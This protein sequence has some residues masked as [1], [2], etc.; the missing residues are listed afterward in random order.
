MRPCSATKCVGRWENINTPDQWRFP[1][2][3]RGA[4]WWDKWVAICI[5]ARRV[6][7]MSRQTKRDAQFRVLPHIKFICYC[8][9]YHPP[10]FLFPISLMETQSPSSNALKP[11]NRLSVSIVPLS[12]ARQR[13]SNLF[14]TRC[15]SYPH[16]VGFI[17]SRPQLIYIHIQGPPLSTAS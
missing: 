4:A 3:G 11:L 16:S 9:D 13:G 10:S 2:T 14:A 5:K 17:F 6:I 7:C 1:P 8:A 12:N 15:I